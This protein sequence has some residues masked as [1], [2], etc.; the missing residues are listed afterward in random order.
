MKSAMIKALCGLMLVSVAA[1]C[2]KKEEGAKEGS[3]AAPAK[4]EKPKPTAPA[5]GQPKVDPAQDPMAAAAAAKAAMAKALGNAK[6][7]VKGKVVNWRK[8]A[9]FVGDKLGAFAA[10]GEL[11]G[12]T[13]GMG[14]FKVS[15]VKRRYTAGE[16]R[17]RV[18][19]VDVSVAPM[20][21]SAFAMAQTISKDS[22]SGVQKGTT[23]S[24]NPAV[25][26]WR[27]RRQRGKLTVLVDGR[28]IVT[29]KLRPAEDADAVLGVA[30]AF[31]FSGLA[32]V[33]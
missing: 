23:V 26:R 7:V 27:K 8:L 12:E 10:K 19:V 15:T 32:K 5:A 30:K 13:G 31:N 3:A 1:G 16:K 6:G 4:A 22:T 20:L 11:R 17:L 24:G 28:F 25:L 33:K 14:G 2:D 18:E 9:P 29:F 21:K